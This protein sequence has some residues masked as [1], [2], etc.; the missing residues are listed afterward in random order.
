MEEPLLRVEEVR[1]SFGGLRAVDGVSLKVEKGSIVG[2]VGP[3][4]S[5]KTTLFN[6]ILGHYPPEQGRVYFNGERIDHL[7]PYQVYKKGLA[8]AFQLPRLFYQLTLLDNMLLA[9][10]E[11]S[12]DGFFSTFLGRRK[13]QEQEKRI[14]NKALEI[15]EILELEHLRL[16]PAEELSG[17]QRKLLEI[18]RAMMSDPILMLLDEPAAGLNPLIA[19]KIFQRIEEFRK[20]GV[21]F[22]I[23]EHR[24]DVL[25]EF[26][27]WIYLMDKGKIVA[28]GKPQEVI[29]SPIFL[30]VYL[31][32]R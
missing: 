1:K 16:S 8:R 12:G 5:G 19:K 27:D 32:E 11:H 18:G 2:L 6:V 29:E 7:P 25:V 20:K 13:W 28:E 15:L 9:V 3:N 30:E 4:G 21:T 22:F 17:G 14:A 10:R 31:G 26:A 23:I 24:L